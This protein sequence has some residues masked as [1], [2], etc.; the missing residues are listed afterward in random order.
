MTMGE[1]AASAVG[2]M[3]DAQA[4]GFELVA[5]AV[6]TEGAELHEAVTA[7]SG[8]EARETLEAV[9]LLAGTYASQLPN[10][11][12]RIERSA[13]ATSEDTPD[14]LGGSEEGEAA[15]VTGWM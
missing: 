1:R 5:L 11:L 2:R 15:I 7:L 13:A 9:L 6:D 8:R 3:V 14:R 12:A 4:R 10:E